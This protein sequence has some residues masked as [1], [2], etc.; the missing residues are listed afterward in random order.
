M[1]LTF[2]RRHEGDGE[3]ARFVSADSCALNEFP[4][5]ISA[6]DPGIELLIA[7]S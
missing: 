3:I 5:M 7:Q 4:G 6:T 2:D 1:A